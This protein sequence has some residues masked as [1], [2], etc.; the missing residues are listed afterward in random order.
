MPAFDRFSFMCNMNYLYLVLRQWKQEGII[1]NITSSHETH[2]LS[3]CSCRSRRERC[4]RS[5]FW[6]TVSCTLQ[7]G[8]NKISNCCLFR[9]WTNEYRCLFCRFGYTVEKIPASQFHLS[10][11]SSEHLSLSVISSWN[12]TVKALRS[13][14]QGNDWSFFFKVFSPWTSYRWQVPVLWYL[15]P[16]LKQK[17]GQNLVVK[18]ILVNVV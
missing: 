15:N 14:C 7:S 4:M 17:W 18:L 16:N 12:T 2:N 10:K 6:N 8:T 3:S 5:I 11:D 13:L 1:F 9:L